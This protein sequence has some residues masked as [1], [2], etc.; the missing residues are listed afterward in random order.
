MCSKICSEKSVGTG[1]EVYRCV[2]FRLG[3]FPSAWVI[4]CKSL[5][6]PPG[7]SPSSDRGTS[8]VGKGA[9]W[10]WALWEEKDNTRTWL[11]GS[12]AVYVYVLVLFVFRVLCG[13]WAVYVLGS[14]HS[15]CCVFHASKFCMLFIFSVPCAMAPH[16]LFYVSSIY[17]A[18]HAICVLYFVFH[19]PH[20]ISMC[21]VLCSVCYMFSGPCVLC[22]MC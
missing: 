11:Q 14:G 19:V 3:L 17:Y 22:S 12:S 10:V 6:V 9:Q 2:C 7:F 1:S 18:P 5:G 15:T 20:F 16:M 21:C 4:P 8:L 13:P